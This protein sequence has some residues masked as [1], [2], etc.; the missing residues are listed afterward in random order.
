MLLQQTNPHQAGWPVSND[1]ETGPAIF[2]GVPAGL[3][4]VSCAILVD[5]IGPYHFARLRAA[6]A[7]FQTIAVEFF[8]MDS[9][10][11]WDKVS[12]AADFRRF[13][14]IGDAGTARTHRTGPS[15]AA[16]VSDALTQIAPAVV[17]IPGWSTQGALAALRW[18]LRSG[19]PAVLLSASSEVGRERAVW[20]E[21]IKRR[22]VRLFSAGVGGGTP[23]AIY[24]HRL[25]IPRDNT[26]LGYDVVDNDYF[27]EGASTARQNASALRQSLGLPEKYFLCI[28]RFVGEKNLP[29]LLDAYA[30]YRR[31]AG[32]TAWKLVL[33]GD[34]P[35][36]PQLLKLREQLGLIDDVLMPGFRQYHELPPYY[37]L[38]G[39]FVLPSV[40]ETW[41]LVVN[42]A[43]ASGLPVLVSDHC[44]CAAD[45][46]RNG[47]NG[48]TFNPH[49]PATIAEHL[50][51]LASPQTD[52]TAMGECSRRIVAHWTPDAFAHSLECAVQ[53]ARVSPRRR[54]RPADRL[55]LKLLLSRQPENS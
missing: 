44:G 53:A 24:L 43:M 7:R 9:T 22:V 14:L 40:S 47:E 2:T 52:L 30:A 45:L 38:A 10:Y 36:K 11:A 37:G 1:A 17:A 28:C 15:L 21:A 25:G 12:G 23:Q 19:T 50:A 32:D 8:G 51:R 31:A 27:A 13:T 35:L 42:E 29:T 46:V 6:A 5:R 33:A 54:A 18:C 41:G 39:A 55:L 26:F 4:G 3:P 20:K 16:R 49:D 48:F 34:G